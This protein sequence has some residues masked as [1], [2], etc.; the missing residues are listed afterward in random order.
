M[1]KQTT[2]IAIIT[3]VTAVV[4]FVGGMK[5]QE[6]KTPQFGRGNP[7][8]LRMGVKS[9]SGEIV[10]QDEQSVTVKMPDGSSK[11]VLLSETTSINKASEATRTDLTVGEKVAV[12]GK[13]NSDGSV[14][15]ENIQI[16][17]IFRGP[18]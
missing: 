12:F 8:G 9:V 14:T 18:R 1:K 4:A 15:A 7:T 3:L 5:Y 13:E 10:S 2:I 16:N 11:I 17:P 6:S